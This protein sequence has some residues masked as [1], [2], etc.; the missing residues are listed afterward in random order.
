MADVFDLSAKRRKL[1]DAGAVPIYVYKKTEIDRDHWHGIV[2]AD[3][4]VELTI[5]RPGPL[6][7]SVE[8]LDLL[9]RDLGK[10][11]GQQQ[12]VLIRLAGDHL[13]VPRPHP[14]RKG[15]YIVR[16]MREERPFRSSKVGVRRPYRTG[17]QKPAFHCDSCQRVLQTGE[18]IWVPDPQPWSYP[19]WN[20]VRLCAA[21]VERPIATRPVELPEK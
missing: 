17:A 9:D 18:R 20:G 13:W 12:D 8:L 4:T 6:R 11:W 3:G 7:L 14:E 19:N 1:E 5:K 21:C 16:H 2:L 15:I 10:L